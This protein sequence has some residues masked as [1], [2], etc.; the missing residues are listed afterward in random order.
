MGCWGLL[1][2]QRKHAMKR[3]LALLVLFLLLTSVAM[4]C[5]VHLPRTGQTT[6]WDNSGNQIPV[7]APGRMVKSR[8]A[9]RGLNL[10]SQTT[11]TKR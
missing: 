8:L 4:A 5:T 6:R 10:G 3:I 2:S 9:N 1:Y 11:V 7:P